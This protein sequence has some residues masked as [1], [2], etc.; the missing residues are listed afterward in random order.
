M[1][2]RYNEVT[3][4]GA[5]VVAIGMGIPAMAADFR[6]K[7]KVPF[8]LL[9]D[10]SKETY[11]ALE[12]R[13]GNLWDVAGPPAWMR[14]VKGLA[15]GHGVAVPQQ[16]PYQLA[17][18]AVVA[19]GGELLFLHRAKTSADNAPVEDVLRVLDRR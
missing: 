4:R 5:D 18:T 8:L 13:R 7:Q 14:A 6:D 19:P 1:R 11:R 12:L 9:V 10:R 17:A 16:D 2:D 15:A 3:E